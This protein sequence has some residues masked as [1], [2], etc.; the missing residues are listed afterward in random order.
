[1]R[2]G[3]FYHV[4]PLIASHAPPPHSRA[5]SCCLLHSWPFYAFVCAE[6]AGLEAACM[7]YSAPKFDIVCAML[8]GPLR[9]YVWCRPRLATV[10]VFHSLWVRG[11]Q[12]ICQVVHVNSL[13]FCRGLSRDK[14][15]KRRATGLPIDY[16]TQLCNG[17]QVAACPFTTSSASSSL[18]A[19]PLLPSSA[20]SASVLSAPWGTLS[21]PTCYA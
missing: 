3:L 4:R 10:C 12:K 14:Q 18:P 21:L 5:L 15:H 7:R 11:R 16:T 9:E 2:R 20:R 19:P 13:L 8:R 17:V 6:S 1:M